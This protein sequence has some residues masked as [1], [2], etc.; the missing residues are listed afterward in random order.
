MDTI[1]RHIAIDFEY[2]SSTPGTICAYGLAFEDG[3][4]E[5]GFVRLHPSAPE[6]KNT[7]YHGITQEQT[8][9]GMA[10]E[11]LY[12]R[13]REL[14]ATGEIFLVAHDLKSDRRAWH[15]AVALFGLEP[16]P[17]KWI[18]SLPIARTEV[19]ANGGG[20]TGVAAMATRY[21]LTIDH[22]NPAD[23]AFISLQ[24]VLRNPPTKI[25]VDD[26]SQ[27]LPGTKHKRR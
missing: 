26:S 19:A 21:G 8:D 25:I 20:L 7:R 15:A 5:H 3:T 2:A 1:R 6:Q 16:L 22:H 11:T 12:E 18:D 27:E 24:V 9:G 10:F 13:I 17:L 14:T 4:K 23:D